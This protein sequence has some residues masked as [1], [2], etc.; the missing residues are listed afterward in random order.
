MGFHLTAACRLTAAGPCHPGTATRPGMSSI[1]ERQQGFTGIHPS[2]PSPHLWPPDGTRT[3]GLSP[4]L[5]TP[6][7]RT[8]RRTPGRGR[9]SALPEVTSSASLTSS[10]A[11][12]HHER[13]HVAQPLEVRLGA[14]V[15]CDRSLPRP[16]AGGWSCP[17]A[18]Y[19]RRECRD[20]PTPGGGHGPGPAP[21]RVHRGG[22]L[23]QRP[24]PAAGDLIQRVPRGGQR[25]PPVRNSSCCHRSPRKSR[26][27]FSGLMAS[28]SDH[29]V[30][31]KSPV[32][33]GSCGITAAC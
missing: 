25:G 12:T 8:Q 33:N 29:G 31:N 6:L 26:R 10:D 11:L 5:R 16:P 24:L 9:A 30:E 14:F 13:H 7:S 4:G 27:E 17:P 3:L 18:P 28:A 22:D 23:A 1:T 32:A 20:S 15:I 19:P 2:Q 21:R